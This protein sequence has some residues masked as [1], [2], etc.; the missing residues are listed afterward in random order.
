MLLS[1]KPAQPVS[2]FLNCLLFH[3]SYYTA[4]SCQHMHCGVHAHLYAQ[5]LPDEAA[6]PAEEPTR[7]MSLASTPACDI[8]LTCKH[9]SCDMPEGCQVRLPLQPRTP[10]GQCLLPASS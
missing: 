2:V 4:W 10:H 6:S 3:S 9:T 1:T 5:T 7:T 8:K